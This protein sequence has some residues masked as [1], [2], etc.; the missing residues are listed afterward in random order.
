LADFIAQGHFQRHVR[1]MRR[2]SRARRDA[3][4]ETWQRLRPGGIVLPEIEAGLHCTVRLDDLAQ[5]ERMTSAAAAAGVEVEGLSR[6]WLTQSST[7]A[8]QAGLVMGFGGVD[9]ASIVAAIETL[10]KVWRC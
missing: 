4:V 5:Q 10:T 1:R 9:E 8:Q 3:M 6:Y 2:A 7:Q